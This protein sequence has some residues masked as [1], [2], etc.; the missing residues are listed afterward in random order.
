MNY[1][2]YLCTKQ[3][4]KTDPKSTHKTTHGVSVQPLENYRSV[5]VLLTNGE[6]TVA[7]ATPVCDQCLAY[8]LKEKSYWHE[9]KAS[10]LAMLESHPPHPELDDLRKARLPLYI[11]DVKDLTKN[12]EKDGVIQ[13]Q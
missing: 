6:Y 11:T 10:L 9:L 1:Q 13:C 3:I 12:L 7:Y 8:L 5:D 4:A 2:C